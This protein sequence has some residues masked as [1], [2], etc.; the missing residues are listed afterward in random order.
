MQT[1]IT[2]GVIVL[3]IAII[4]IAVMLVQFF[5][6]LNVLIKQTDETIQHLQM[7]ADQIIARVDVSL[8][9]LNT[10]SK[11]LT[12]KMDKLDSTFSAVDSIGEGVSSLSNHVRDKVSHPPEW[13][14]RALEL[15]TAG[16][17][18]YKGFDRMR[19]MDERRTEVKQ[20]VQA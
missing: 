8:E 14:D 17:T 10:I 13:A 1:A 16:F 12:G 20:R 3:A 15:L 18:V 5:R 6:N 7:N 19:Q 2:I 4:V 11:D 9:D